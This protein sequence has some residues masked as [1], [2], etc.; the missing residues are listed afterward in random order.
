MSALYQNNMFNWIFIELAYWQNSPGVGMSIH[1]ETLSWFWTNRSLLVLIN[2]ACV[3]KKQQIPMLQSLLS[4]LPIS[5]PMWLS[6]WMWYNLIPNECLALFILTWHAASHSLAILIHR[7]QV[8]KI[9]DSWCF[10][11]SWVFFSTN[12]ANIILHV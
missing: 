11:Y 6:R 5:P 12:K 1:S 7:S 4:T 3:A 2:D 9:V 8:F 10:E